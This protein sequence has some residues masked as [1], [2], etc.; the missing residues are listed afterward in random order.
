ML[1]IDNALPLF[2][3]GETKW[4]NLYDPFTLSLTDWVQ[5]HVYML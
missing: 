5:I 1:L 2:L 3:A 4:G